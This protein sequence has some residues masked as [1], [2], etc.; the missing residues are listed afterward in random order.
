M[1]QPKF[2]TILVEPLLELGAHRKIKI[3]RCLGSLVL[4]NLVKNVF[5]NKLYSCNVGSQICYI[6]YNNLTKMNIFINFSD[7]LLILTTL[8][9]PALFFLSLFS[10]FSLFFFFL[11]FISFFHLFLI[12]FS[13]T[14]FFFQLFFLL[15]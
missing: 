4:N 1:L 12:F 10:P 7:A 11:S 9:A 15:F 5:W 2:S 6:M 3:F 8:P 14:F 13:L